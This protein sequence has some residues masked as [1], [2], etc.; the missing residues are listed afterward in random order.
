MEN[1]AL[2]NKI[3]R[4]VY[5]IWFLKRSAPVVFLQ[6]PLMAWFLAMEHKYV[7]FKAVASNTWGALGSPSSL[8]H[9]TVSAFQ[10]TQPLVALMAVAIGLFA[11]LAITSVI[12]N[13]RAVYNQKPVAVPVRLD[14]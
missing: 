9:Y 12:R 7:A 10:N 13:I 11:V 14:K 1:Q 6:L 5:T 2:R 3:M 8:Y 4:R